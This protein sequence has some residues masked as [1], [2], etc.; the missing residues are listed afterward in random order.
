MM[1]F[2]EVPVT[3]EPGICIREEKLEVRLDNDFFI[4]KEGLEDLMASIP[5]E[6]EEIERL[7]REQEASKK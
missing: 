5:I 7:M 4:R 6:V 2:Q 3:I 1:G